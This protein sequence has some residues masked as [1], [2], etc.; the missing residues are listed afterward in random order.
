MKFSRLF[1]LGL[2]VC[3]TISATAQDI[4]FSLFHMSPL[5][6][7]PAQTGAFTGTARIGGIYRDQWSS[8]LNDQFTTPSFYVDSPIMRGFGRNDWV[9]VGMVSYSDKSGSLDL[10]RSA[11]LFSAAY[12][13]GLDRDG[14]NT[15][16]LGVQFGS[17]TRKLNTDNIVLGSAIDFDNTDPFAAAQGNV[18]EDQGFGGSNE[19]DN[20]FLNISAGLMFRSKINDESN[21]EFGLSFNHINQGEYNL[22]SSQDSDGQKIPM[23]INGH[24]R[25]RYQFSENWS[26]T[27]GFLFRSISGTKP[28]IG[29]QSWAGRRINDEFTL[30]FGAGYRLSDAAEIL[31]GVDYMEDLRVALSYDIN[32]SSLNTATNYSGGFELSAYYIIKLYKK[33]S[34][35]PAS[36]CPKF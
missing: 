4:H 21:L 28:E 14:K 31:V 23:N 9:G 8:F 3:G 22:I 12:H 36:L 10:G 2:I 24:G 32:V 34:A 7:N 30:N 15:L 25:F 26:I 27:P 13:R 35:D 16:T 20:N 11:F 19:L 5:T 6:L 33:P 18:T 29:L 1:M 17:T